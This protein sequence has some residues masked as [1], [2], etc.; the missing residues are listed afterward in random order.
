MSFLTWQILG[1]INSQIRL[2]EFFSV[3]NVITNL[4]QS[5]LGI[6]HLDALIFI[7]KKWIIDVHVG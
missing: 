3:A 2:K 4:Q 6:E 7:V 5:K 1:I